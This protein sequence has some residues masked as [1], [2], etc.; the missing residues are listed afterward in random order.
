MMLTD[1]RRATGVEN[2]G[3]R[4]AVT[5]EAVAVMGFH[6]RLFKEGTRRGRTAVAKDLRKGTR[7]AKKAWQEAR[8]CV[9]KRERADCCV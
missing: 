6:K 3:L 7:V 2:G 9:S 4:V 5:R 1:I 8:V